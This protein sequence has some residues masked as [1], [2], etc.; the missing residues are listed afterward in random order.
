MARVVIC[1]GPLLGPAL[2]AS[3]GVRR[4]GRPQRPADSD[5]A[6]DAGERAAGD[7]RGR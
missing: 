7:G 1:Y 6:G 4:G 5:V 3:G 2:A